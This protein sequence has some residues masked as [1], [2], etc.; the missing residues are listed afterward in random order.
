VKHAPYAHPIAL[1][2]YPSLKPY[3]HARTACTL[4]FPLPVRPMA[5]GEA[6]ISHLEPD[7]AH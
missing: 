5:H 6:K 4:P 2:T 7:R 3:Y 1:P